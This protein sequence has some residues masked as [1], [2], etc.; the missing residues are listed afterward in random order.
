MAPQKR[1][2][3]PR[4]YFGCDKPARYPAEEPRW[5]SQ[6]C[7]AEWAVAMIEGDDQAWNGSEWRRD[8][9]KEAGG[10]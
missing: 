10:Q 6:R 2:T 4:C 3:K 1:K 7:A 8:P 5:C 9:A